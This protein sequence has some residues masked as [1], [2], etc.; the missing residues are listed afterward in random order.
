MK[1]RTFLLASATLFVPVPACPAPFVQKF[2]LEGAAT[3]TFLRPLGPAVLRFVQDTS[4]AKTV[5]WPTGLGRLPAL[6]TLVGE[7]EFF[8]LK[9]HGGDDPATARIE[10]IRD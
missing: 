2:C 7:P 5:T 3:I 8:R 1:R 10:V 4:P 6:S 9:L